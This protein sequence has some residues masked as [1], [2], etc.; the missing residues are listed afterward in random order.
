MT[1]Y[2]LG[3]LL[4]SEGS[5]KYSMIG[6]IAGTIANLILDPLFIFT[7]NMG[8]KG[9]A[10]ATVLGNVLGTIIPVIFYISKK[11]LLTPDFKV[12]LP[13]K[14]IIINIFK[15]GLPSMLETMLTSIAFIINNNLAVGYGELTVT[16]MGISQKIISI[17]QNIY[18]GFAAGNQPLMGYNYGA[19][20]YKRMLS[21]LKAG[22]I[23]VT[24]A[25][26]MVMCI[27]GFFAPFLISIFSDTKEVIAIGAKVLRTNMFCL[28]FVGSISMVR[29]SYQAIGKALK[30]FL[31]TIIRQF[32]LYV[33]LLILLNKFLGF[34]GMIWAQ[35]VTEAIMMA[36]SVIMFVKTVKSLINLT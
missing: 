2:A 23:S 25:E 29:M 18:Q 32:V 28:L 24:I 7:F 11:S 26:A 9:A 16:A 15:V 5:T 8:I 13:D 30:A 4:R 36:V 1:N 6:M 17:G 12:F 14:E 22:L 20:N 34:N 3:Q 35:P 31:I 19:K 27:Y 21:V 10:V 33:P